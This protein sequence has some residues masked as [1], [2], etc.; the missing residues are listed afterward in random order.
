MSDYL[1]ADIHKLMDEMNNG[2]LPREA[3]EVVKFGSV[4]MADMGLK[5]ADPTNVSL[6]ELLVSVAMFVDQNFTWL[7][8]RDMPEEQ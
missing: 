4:V 2:R 1:P 8:T 6:Y 7:G 5:A 3:N